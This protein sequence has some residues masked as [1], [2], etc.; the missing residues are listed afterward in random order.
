MDM[1][2]RFRQLATPLAFFEYAQEDPDRWEQIRGMKILHCDKRVGV[3]TG[4]V[5]VTYN[6]GRKKTCGGIL[7]AFDQSDATRP[8]ERFNLQ[9]FADGT[10]AA[11]VVEPE[12]EIYRLL[13]DQR[14]DAA[15]KVYEANRDRV[16]EAGLRYRHKRQIM[17]CLAA[18]DFASA[19]SIHVQTAAWPWSDY[20]ECKGRALMEFFRSE[21]DTDLSPEQG[22]ALAHV[23]QGNLLITARAGSGKTRVLTGIAALLMEKYGVTPEKMCALAFNRKAAGELRERLREVY[24]T[25]HTGF[26]R[27]FHSLAWNLTRPT[28][29]ALY[30]GDQGPKLTKFMRQTVHSALTPSFKLKLYQCF[31]EEMQAWDQL[32]AGLSPED[33][34]ALIRN[35]SWISL[36][37]EPVKSTGEKV[38]ADFLFEHDVK[39]LYERIV[40]WGE[41]LYRPDF[42]ILQDERP[43]VIEHWALDPTKPGATLP[44]G[45]NITAKEYLSQIVAKRDFWKQKGLVLLE[46]N[47]A[48]LCQGRRIFE[49]LL[50]D[51]LKRNGVVINRLPEDVLAHRVCEGQISNIARLFTQLV[52]RTRK[53]GWSAAELAQRVKGWKTEDSRET[54][55]L[56]LGIEVMKSYEERCRQEGYVDF[57][58]IMQRATALVKRTAG[59]CQIQRDRKGCVRDLKWL[60]VD[61]FQDFSSQFH[62]LIQAIRATAKDT[63]VICVGDDWQ[64][65]NAFAGSELTFFRE[66]ETLFPPSVRLHLVDNHRSAPEVVNAGN[67][68]M[69]GRGNP[70]RATKETS[71]SVEIKDINTVWIELRRNPDFEKE[72]KADERY[73]FLLAGI[74]TKPHDSAEIQ[75]RYVKFIHQTLR[76]RNLLGKTVALLSRVNKFHRVTMLDLLE[77]LKSVFTAQEREAIGDFSSK[78]SAGA[79]HNFKGKEADVVFVVEVCRGRF[80]LVHANESYFRIFGR[81]VREVLEEERRVFYVAVTRAKSHLWL[82]TEGDR[83]SDY[84]F[85]CF[86]EEMTRLG[87]RPT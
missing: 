42:T 26:A 75:A 76:D 1:P 54:I 84:L 47:A 44:D 34:L 77:K 35:L 67:N 13:I 62:N 73:R 2:D 70:A 58:V 24:K 56:T 22:L 86:P 52:L 80:P 53:A 28:E 45:W 33:R 83:P 51:L 48:Q 50:R 55:F 74:D 87:L 8:A 37:G 81:D 20:A 19:D 3:I 25:Q 68:V 40:F 27:T 79:V 36:A 4:I 14:F 23:S 43:I 41:R 21:H 11:F 30:D 69:N 29:K 12:L 6:A 63:R 15:D 82:L 38:I 17:E 78:F 39:Y 49:E 85:E 65:I 31:R 64:A 7:I 59:N 60:L 5:T 71:G 61:E 57:D 9:E 46:T 66:F 72:R 16:D 18:R 32:G 10:I